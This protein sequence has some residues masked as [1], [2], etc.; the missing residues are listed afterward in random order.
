MFELK[1]KCYFV[2]AYLDKQSESIILLGLKKLVFSLKIN[3]K[4]KQLMGNLRKKRKRK[5][6][7]HKRRKNLKAQR[8]KK[9]K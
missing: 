7:K 1:K 6:S 3:K 2:E 9:N 4:R 5:I 8:H